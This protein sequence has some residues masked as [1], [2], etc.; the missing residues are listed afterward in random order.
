MDAIE[1]VQWPGWSVVR[2]IG[3]GGFGAVYEIQRDVLGETERAALKVITIPENSADIEDLRVEG[4]DNESITMR[5]QSYLADF[6]KEYSTMAKMK[7][8]PNV[9][10]CDD[11][12][13]VQHDDGIGWDIYIKMELLTP[14]MKCLDRVESESAIIDLGIAMCNALALCKERNIV[15]RDIKPQNIFISQDG[16]FKLGDFGIA[17][18]AER[19]TSGTK[20]GTYK[21][22]APEVYNNR[23]YGPAADQYSLGLVMYWLLNDRRT[24]FSPKK[25]TASEE[26]MA[27]KRRFDG[28]QIPAPAHGS[29]QLQAIVLKACSYDPKQRYASASDM[30]NAL[31]ALKVGNGATPIGLINE[32]EEHHDA[33]ADASSE[34]V[35][36]GAVPVISTE[37]TVAGSAPFVPTGDVLEGNASEF[38]AEDAEAPTVGYRERVP[39]SL[40]RKPKKVVK[41]RRRG[42]IA[43]IAI[44]AGV[45]ICGTLLLVV[46]AVNSNKGRTKWSEWADSLPKQVTADNYLIES[47]TLYSSRK[48][49]MAQSTTG[50]D[51]EGWELC[52]T[53]GV[54]W[55]EWSQTPISKSDTRE[56][57]TETRYRYR[58]QETTT[59]TSSNLPGWTRY[60]ET[61]AQGDW[62]SWS[63]WSTDF[64]SSSDSREVE[65]KTQYR[66]RDIS[67]STQYTD[68]GSWS[69]WQDSYVASNDLTDVET[70]TAYHYYYFV[71]SN[72]GAHMHGYGPCYSWAGGCGSNSVSRDSYTAV[73]C[74]IPYSDASDFYGTGTYYTDS[75]GEGRGFAYIYSGSQ[76][77][78][79]PI[80]QYRY[81]TRST[82]QVMDNYG[83]WSSWSD[84]SCSSSSSREVDTR[85]VYRYRT[86]SAP[87]TYRFYRWKDW[88]DWSTAAPGKTADREVQSATFYRYRDKTAQSTYC[89][90]RWSDWSEYSPEKS[91]A[92]DT[93]E[94]RTTTQ[95]RYR[96]K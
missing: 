88:S 61:D 62:G 50:D 29:K 59:S 91:K 12:K 64:V 11:V 85:T 26:D 72:C 28:E 70:R 54:A 55:S 9:V 24:P 23:P 33:A 63:S 35:T 31:Q 27:R 79:A 80:T 19:T 89:F 58:D 67:Y 15:H 43:L 2:L 16:T 32:L 57:Q 56:V 69:E 53:D 7:G 25:A 10:Y 82:T 38:P 5:F 95:Y 21:Y 40:Q 60:D 45:V 68:W 1:H 92:S 81:R 18:T 17:K 20:I 4:Y 52:E 66:Y 65:A 3:R 37:N 49:E 76:H 84:A 93:V 44:A 6:V 78:V 8:H 34:D 87:S 77:Y 90:K 75:T 71:C 74:A 30:L 86:R 47:R 36:V 14:I 96:S 94:V 48:L 22:M 51:M 83:S 42:A 13:Y 39:D 46:G 73:R 41:K